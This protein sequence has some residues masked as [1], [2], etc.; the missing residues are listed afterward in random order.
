MGLREFFEN[1]FAGGKEAGAGRPNLGIAGP[2]ERH[3]RAPPSPDVAAR[4]EPSAPEAAYKKGDVIGGNY[5]VHSLLGRGGFGEVYLVYSRQLREALAFKTFRQKVPLDAEGKQ[6]FKREA[7]L[8]VNLEKHPF[9]LAAHLVE[10]FYGRLFV[11]M[12]YIAPDDRAR[13]SLADHLACARGPLDT[14]QA[15]K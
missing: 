9:I 4:Y 12:D 14:D 15:L 10:E 1:L 8:W 13:V 3:R 5:E 7:L 11:G 6:N 2:P